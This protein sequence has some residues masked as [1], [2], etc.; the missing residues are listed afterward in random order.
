MEELLA[1]AI[2]YA[3]EGF[4][5]SEVIADDWARAVP[6][7]ME[8]PGFCETYTVNGRAPRKARSFEI[9]VW[10]ARWKKSPAKEEMLITKETSPGLLIRRCRRPEGFF[11][12]VIWQNIT[13][14]GWNRFQPVT[15]V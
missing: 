13:P 4:P 8:F 5:V 3:L 6:L 1:P 11:P 2:G 15:V 9:L 7:F 10:L 12:G 14:I